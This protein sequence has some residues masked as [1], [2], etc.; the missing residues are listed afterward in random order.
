MTTDECPLTREELIE[1]NRKLH[2]RCQRAESELERG[3]R[4]LSRQ[5]ESLKWYTGLTQE[6]LEKAWR[7]QAE[8]N[9]MLRSVPKS[10]FWQRLRWLAFGDN[11]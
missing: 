3:Q 9:G 6:H 2:R 5:F 8:L 7:M 4:Y 1:Q 11:T 10:T